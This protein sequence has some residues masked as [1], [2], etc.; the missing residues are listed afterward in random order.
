MV[1]NPEGRRPSRRPKCRWED[2]IKM[3]VKEIE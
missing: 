2:H 3:D 1:G